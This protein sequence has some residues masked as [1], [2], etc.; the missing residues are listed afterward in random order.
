MGCRIKV[1]YLID[2][3]LIDNNLNIIDFGIVFSGFH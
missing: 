3:V 2:D 1:D